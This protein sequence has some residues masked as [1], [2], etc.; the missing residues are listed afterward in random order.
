VSATF[1]RELMRKTALF[2]AD[3]SHNSV[4]FIVEDRHVELELIYTYDFPVVAHL[5]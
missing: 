5:S 4:E 3:E 2:A 1:I